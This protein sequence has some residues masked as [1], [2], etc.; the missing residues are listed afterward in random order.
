MLDLFCGTGNLGLEAWSRGARS[1]VLVDCHKDSMQLAERNRNLIDA[2]DVALMR[3][4]VLQ[5]LSNLARQKQTF[6]WIL[7]DP[8]YQQGWITR[9]LEADSLLSVI[10]ETGVLVFEHSR[11]ESPELLAAADKRWRVTRQATYGDTVVSFLT[12][13]SGELDQQEEGELC[14]E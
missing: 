10:G 11:R 4:D 3:G 14:E 9:L 1:V 5:V 7:C 2:K 6:Q 12:R 8:P 13:P